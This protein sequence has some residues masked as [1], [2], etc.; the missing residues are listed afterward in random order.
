M[1]GVLSLSI[2]YFYL[3]HLLVVGFR[4]GAAL[5]FAPI[6]GH[7]AF[8]QYLR[9]LLVF[10][11]AFVIANVTPWSE[12]AY[13]N[14]GTVLP[15]E[16]LIG[17]LLSVGIRIAFAGLHF[18]GHLISY[19]LGFSTIQT[20]DPTT[21]NRSTLI[22]GFLTMFGYALI[23]ATNQHHVILRALAESYRA[24]PVGSVV[25]PG[26]WFERL[27]AAGGQIFAIGWKIALPVFIATSLIEVTAA[28]LARMQPQMSTMVVTAPL[29]VFIGIFVLG[30]TLVFLPR[31]FG[32]VI[33]V[34]VLRK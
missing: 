22:S 9:I 5:L 20:I 29:K 3:I 33:E 23:L 34:I 13:L 11:V 15:T 25:Q 14:P 6:W 4:V 12:A 2:P 30:A 7:Q 17:L 24:F 16:F 31:A 1:P 32:S 26:Q 10:S 18:G 28:F 21:A 8:P 19:H 27:F